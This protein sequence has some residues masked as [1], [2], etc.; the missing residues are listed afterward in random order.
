MLG[1]GKGVGLD[2]VLGEAAG[3]ELH[4]HKVDDVGM[5]R[6]PLVH[7]VVGAL[8]ASLAYDKTGRPLADAPRLRYT[9]H[10]DAYHH[11]PVGP[12]IHPIN[13]HL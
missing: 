8:T 7:A 1:P 3:A 10:L 2:Q 13:R 4:V 11:T 6:A 5:L 9:H 12:T